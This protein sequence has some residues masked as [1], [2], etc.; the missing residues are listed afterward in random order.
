MK[1]P[2]HR[3][4][5]KPL[6]FDFISRLLGWLQMR[7]SAVFDRKPK[8]T[9]QKSGKQARHEKRETYESASASYQRYY[10]PEEKKDRRWVTLAVVVLFA[11][12]FIFGAVK[13][14]AYGWDYVSSRLASN[15]LRKVYYDMATDVP[16]H[17]PDPT[18]T[19]TPPP[20]AASTPAPAATQAAAPSATPRT[21]PVQ[22]YPNNPYLVASSRFV[23]L[24]RQNKDIIGWL[25]IEGM[26]DEV[27]VQRDNAYYLDRDYRGYH[28][29][30]GAIFLDESTSL[31]R[32][33]YTLMLYGHNMKTGA[34]FGNLR[35]FENLAFYK[36]NP[37]MTFDTM[38]EDGRYVIFAVG[39]VSLDYQSWRY[40]NLSSLNSNNVD[41]R[42]EAL[43]MLTRASV[44]SSG[45]T[46][47]PEDQVLLL[48]TC[49]DNDDERRVVAARRIRDGE[50][51][52]SLR[53]MVDQSYMR[54]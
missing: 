50:D 5:M 46:V 24:Q 33:P 28:N 43:T 49:V 1:H 29:V 16:T 48:V 2:L 38:Y 3:R 40:L 21:L 39:T 35:N 20:I 17:T 10:S 52:E 13:L 26:I 14:I 41:K 47:Q 31:N 7:L 54:Q 19:P 15:E 37:F 42:Q 18:G 34:M 45:V 30:N 12:M 23:Q 25:T 9:G 22:Y 27:V 4:E 51:E 11:G 53:K 44:F 8:Q 6:L 36:K 32:R